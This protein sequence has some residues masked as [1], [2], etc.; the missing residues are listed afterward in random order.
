MCLLFLVL[1]VVGFVF[2]LCLVC[3]WVLFGCCWVGVCLELGICVLGVFDVVVCW[4]RVFGLGCIELVVVL[5][6][7]CFGGL[8]LFGVGRVLM[9]VCL[10]LGVFWFGF[11]SVGL[12]ALGLFGFWQV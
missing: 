5:S 1:G 7:F 10:V 6:V 4:I 8:D 11:G 3:V 2:G 9:C 12:G